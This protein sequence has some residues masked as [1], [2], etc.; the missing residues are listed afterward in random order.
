MNKIFFSSSAASLWC[1]RIAYS[2]TQSNFNN[3]VS[4]S[5]LTLFLCLI[6]YFL[7]LLYPVHELNVIIRRFWKTNRK[8]KLLNTLSLAFCAS[9]SLSFLSSTLF[10]LLLLPSFQLCHTTNTRSLKFFFVFFFVL[11]FNVFS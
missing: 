1:L 9:R 10:L 6:L 8:R 4:S 11:F 5:S 7:L 3:F 2:S